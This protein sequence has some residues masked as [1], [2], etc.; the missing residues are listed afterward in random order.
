[1]DKH[2]RPYKCTVEGCEKLPGFTYSGGLLRHEREVHHKHGGPKNP[3]NCP[4]PNCKRN[5][6]KGFSRQEN[7][8]EHMRRVHTNNGL[9]LVP[10]LVSGLAAPVGAGMA[11]SDESEDD[12]ERQAAAKR[13]PSTSAPV[14]T[15]GGAS[16]ASVVVPVL[17]GVASP[18]TAA[19][20][21][22]KRKRPSTANHATAATTAAAAMANLDSADAEQLKGEIKRMR[23]ENDE[24]RQQVE[25][26]TRQ[27]EAH[28]RQSAAMM[29]QIAQL[30][31]ALKLGAP[32]AIM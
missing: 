11:G 1:M 22:N 27:L 31:A 20:A 14:T 16:G 3:L 17:A 23:L 25:A 21:S 28:S 9:A 6:G 7:L 12:V 10:G 5:T 24:L 30:Q 18:T 32:E 26:Q 19:G 13:T 15:N 8:N 29:Q 2:D 4:H